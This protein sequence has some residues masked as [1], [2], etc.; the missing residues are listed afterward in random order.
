MSLMFRTRR[1]TAAAPEATT[2]P[3]GIPAPPSLVSSALGASFPFPE[4]GDE[5]RFQR[6]PAHHAE[7][8]FVRGREFG[9]RGI[10]V[11]DMRGKPL[12][13]PAGKYELVLS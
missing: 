5:V 7:T 8:G 12:R 6:S 13:L 3:R 11:V 2:S 9:T 4:I 10:D 1:I